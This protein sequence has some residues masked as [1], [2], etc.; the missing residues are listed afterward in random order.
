MMQ[1]VKPPQGNGAYD[2]KGCENLRAWTW[3]HSQHA[4]NQQYREHETID[5]GDL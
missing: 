4:N 1:A 5:D 2:D 3:C